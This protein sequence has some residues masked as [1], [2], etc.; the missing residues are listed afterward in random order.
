[1][2]EKIVVEPKEKASATVIWLHGLGADGH[3]FAALL[4]QLQLPENHDIRFVFPHAPIRPISLSGGWPM[5]GWYDIYGLDEFA[6]QD[7]A[8]IRLMAD[9]IRDLIAQEH[10]AGIPHHKIV[11]AGFSQG[12]AMAL[13][14]ALT[15]QQPLAGVLALSTYLPLSDIL[16]A[17]AQ[18]KKHT[19]PILM[20]HGEEDLVIPIRYA[21][22][23]KDVLQALG[24]SVN[25]QIYPMAHSVCQP[26]VVLIRDWLLQQLAK[27]M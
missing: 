10:A 5:R 12:G 6:R 19:L 14:T 13:Y 26:E 27:A 21:S 25:W 17:E 4:P 8:G 23:S 3:D 2:L 18:A 7:E 20:A 16:K 11:L 15:H 22:L 9:S 24:Y 1:M